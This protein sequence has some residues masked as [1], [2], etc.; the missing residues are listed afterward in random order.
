[1]ATVSAVTQQFSG[2]TFGTGPYTTTAFTPPNNSLL[3]IFTELLNNASADPGQG[4]TPIDNLGA[5]ALTYTSRA[6]SFQG[7]AFSHA[8]T[9][10]TA[11]V[12]TGASMT[13]TLNDGAQSVYQ[14]VI[15]VAAVTGYDTGTP[16][17][18]KATVSTNVAD[19]AE[20]LT[21][22]AAPATNDITFAM[23]CIDDSGSA[24]NPTMGT[25]SWTNVYDGVSNLGSNLNYRTAS[26]STSVPWTDVYTGA[27]SFDKGILLALVIKAS[28][29]VSANAVFADVTVTATNPAVTGDALPTPTLR[30]V[31][32][33]G[34]RP[35]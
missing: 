13:I 4:E 28:G 18:G 27:G 24:A 34:L 15:T 9:C 23:T 31:T 20:T 35:G 2:T 29:A 33:S 25:G 7:V 6:N 5:G 1:M 19:G 14:Y 12:T 11:P 8:V 17:G 30:T 21:L 26:T 3:V 10:W 22:D 16:T 32:R